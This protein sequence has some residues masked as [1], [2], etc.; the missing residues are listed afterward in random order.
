VPTPVLIEFVIFISGGALDALCSRTS[1]VFATALSPLVL[2]R[3]SA[4]PLVTQR[5]IVGPSEIK[6]MIIPHMMDEKIPRII[7]LVWT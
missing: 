5:F 3:L 7:D 4:T 2:L 6:F 1:R